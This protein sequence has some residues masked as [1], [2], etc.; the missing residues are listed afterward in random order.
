MLISL[1][2]KLE[3]TVRTSFYYFILRFL[4]QLL[5]LGLG[6]QYGKLEDGSGCGCL[7]LVKLC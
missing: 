4:P 1:L 6:C 2:Y 3:L 7:W 5:H